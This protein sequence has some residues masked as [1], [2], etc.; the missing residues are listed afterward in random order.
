MSNKFN[1]T[2]TA[3]ALAF[4][5]MFFAM[6]SLTTTGTALAQ[7]E[8]EAQVRIIHTVFDAPAVDVYLNG[9]K[10]VGGLEYKGISPRVAI[11]GGPYNI[12]VTPAGKSEALIQ[13]DLTLKNGE[14]Y[15]LVAIGKLDSMSLKALTDDLSPLE[16]GK[17]R[18]RLVHTSPDTPAVDVVANNSMLLVPNLGFAEASSYIP[19]NAMSV[20]VEVRPSGTTRASLT[21]PS[22]TLEAGKAY[23]VYVV[24]TSSGTPALS[25]LPVADTVTLAGAKVSEALPESGPPPGPAA[26]QSAGS[27]PK[28]GSEYPLAASLLVIASAA[29]LAIGGGATLR[30]RK[31]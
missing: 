23:T 25:A 12:K 28:T 14:N 9:N 26:N 24:G 8:Q 5:S 29:A 1:R 22:L 11:S 4:A 21:V 13:T 30:R 31:S 2:I 18:L 10:M 15:S 3:S 27:L 7:P 17:T 20:D 16:V 19:L 6:F